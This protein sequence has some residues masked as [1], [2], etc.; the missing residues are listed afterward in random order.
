M[1]VTF[2]TH[3]TLCH[4]AV[5]ITCPAA[6]TTPTPI[7]DHCPQCTLHRAKRAWMV[8]QD[9][10]GALHWRT[11]AARREYCRARAREAEGGDGD[12]VAARRRK[13]GDGGKRVA[14]ADDVVEGSGRPTEAFARGRRATYVPGRYAG[15]WVDTSGKGVTFTVFYGEERE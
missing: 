14:F 2:T 10:F 11:A 15:D 12:A 13:T 3:A 5:T 7:P 8:A 1:T 9:L 4:H 6:A